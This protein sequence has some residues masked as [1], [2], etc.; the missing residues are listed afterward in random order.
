M[1]TTLTDQNIS[2]TYL[3]LLH[4]QGAIFPA[5]GQVLMY[6]G[7]GN[8]TSISIGRTGKGVSV[9]GTLSASLLQSGG[10]SYP[11]ADGS[12]GQYLG[13]DGA[14]ALTFYSVGSG[15]LPNLDP[16]PSN[17]YRSISAISVD[18]KG[19]VTGVV[20]GAGSSDT[21]AQ[22]R[23]VTPINLFY[24][25][26]SYSDTIDASQSN[27]PADATYAVL[28]IRYSYHWDQSDSGG[29]GYTKISVNGVDAV[30]CGTEPSGTWG[31]RGDDDEIGYTGVQEWY[32]KLDGSNN[33]TINVDS[34]G[35]SSYPEFTMVVQVDLLG[36]TN[37]NTL[38][39][40]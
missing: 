21:T 7:G 14:G 22:Y 17:I 15:T 27:M 24:V 1:A 33:F 34:S 6:D 29:Y 39:N 30:V 37:F 9:T 36:Y 13:T 31:M 2:D 26:N 16:D 10:L 23:Y 18:A 4:A 35:A 40:P 5:S 12:A 8:A 32:A 38:T 19:R 28:R 11:Q 3:G 25:T 20:T